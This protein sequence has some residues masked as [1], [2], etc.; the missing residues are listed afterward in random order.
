M[1][2]YGVGLYSM[3]TK[4]FFEQRDFGALIT[5]G[6]WLI[7]PLVKALGAKIGR[8]PAARWKTV[9]AETAGAPFG[10]FCFAYEAWRGRADRRSATCCGASIRR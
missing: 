4:R 9:L 7:G 3:L 6:R 10:P 1:F 8:R 5:G 2:G